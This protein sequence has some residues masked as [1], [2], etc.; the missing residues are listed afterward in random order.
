MSSQDIWRQEE[1][2]RHLSRGP[3]LAVEYTGPS[4]LRFQVRVNRR[5]VD[6]TGQA[7]HTLNSVDLALTWLF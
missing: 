5:R 6:A 7:P 3:V 2:E 4:G 1:F